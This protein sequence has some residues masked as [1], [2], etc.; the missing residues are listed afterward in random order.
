VECGTLPYLPPSLYVTLTTG[1]ALFIACLFG[2]LS[3]KCGSRSAVDY[4]DSDPISDAN[5]AFAHGDRRLLAIRGPGVLVIPVAWGPRSRAGSGHTQDT[6][7]VS[8]SDGLHFVAAVRDSADPRQPAPTQLTYV[9]KYNKELLRLCFGRCGVA[10]APR[11]APS[12]PSPLLTLLI[13]AALVPIVKRW[14]RE[15]AWRSQPIP[16][17]EG[18]V[19]LELGTRYRV[20]A[21]VSV[22]CGCGLALWI[23]PRRGSLEG[24]DL[25]GLG[26][27]AAG[28]ALTGAWMFVIA[29]ATSVTVSGDGVRATTV[30]RRERRLRWR[31]INDVRYNPVTSS[32][33]FRA[34]GRRRVRVCIYTRGI[35]TIVPH[36][37]TSVPQTAFR[38]LAR[39]IALALQ[40]AT[41]AG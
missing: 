16:G 17:P 7:L 36:L 9:E 3:A 2:T 34:P 22:L 18:S 21:T 35:S 12:A 31:E 30:L 19:R 40:R 11:P 10:H 39:V 38:G 15:E 13:T 25:V 33:V 28:F 26:A 8:L 37:F 23:A 24:N 4:R 1:R 29:N 14:L 27:V 20:L 32:F 41:N 5:R 6:A